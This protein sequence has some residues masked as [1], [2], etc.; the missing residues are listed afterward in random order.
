[1][2]RDASRRV[3][4][5][6]GQRHSLR[7]EAAAPPGGGTAD[8]SV[9]AAPWQHSEQAVAAAAPVTASFGLCASLNI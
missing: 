8:I 3:E 1:M 2:R 7:G 5:I 9:P 4:G 6:F